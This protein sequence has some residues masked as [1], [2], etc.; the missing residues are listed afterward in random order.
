MNESEEFL[1]IKR[2]MDQKVSDIKMPPNFDSRRAD[3]QMFSVLSLSCLTVS[4]PV[5]LHARV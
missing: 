4:P 2:A 3:Q 5:S 1:D